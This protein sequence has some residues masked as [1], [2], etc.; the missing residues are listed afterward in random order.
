MVLH[1]AHLAPGHLAPY[2]GNSGLDKPQ[3]VEIDQAQN[4]THDVR[5]VDDEEDEILLQM[6]GVADGIRTH[7]NRNHNPRTYAANSSTYGHFV[8]DSTPWEA[9]PV[10]EVVGHLLL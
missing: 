9:A 10:L 2:A 3:D 5:I 4:R 8:E 1:Y 7:D 6:N